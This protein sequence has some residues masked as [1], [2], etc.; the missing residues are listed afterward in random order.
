MQTMWELRLGGMAEDARKRRD[1]DSAGQENR[2]F[3]SVIV[4]RERSHRSLHLDDCIDGSRSQKALESC[5]SHPGGKE[6]MVLIWGAGYRE[7][8]YVALGVGLWRIDERDVHVLAGFELKACGF[9]E[10]KAH[11]PF[12]QRLS[13]F[14]FAR[15]RGCHLAPCLPGW[16]PLALLTGVRSAVRG[17]AANE[18]ITPS[19]SA[20]FS[21]ASH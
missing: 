4:Q 1:P 13:V 3:G 14:E 12:C 16:R 11:G 10:V 21:M 20:L 8:S 2:G 18:P 15:K 5:V 17:Y 7:R 6:Q 9:G 19:F